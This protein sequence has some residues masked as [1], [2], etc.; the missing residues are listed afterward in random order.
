MPKT[1]ATANIAR[2]DDS[3]RP[4]FGSG[5]EV[6]ATFRARESAKEEALIPTLR[7]EGPS[8]CRSGRVPSRP[9]ANG[10]RRADQLSRPPGVDAKRGLVQHRQ[11]FVEVRQDFSVVL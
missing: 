4:S 10:A 9:D 1:T 8:K 5:R 6:A 3:R 2:R 11:A 7:C